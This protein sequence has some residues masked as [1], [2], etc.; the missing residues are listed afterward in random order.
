MRRNT[1]PAG[2]RVPSLAAF[3]SRN[4]IGSIP[5][6]RASSSTADSA[7]KAAAGDPGARYAADFCVFT[8]TSS[9]SI[10]A[11]GITYGASIV[12]QPD[13]TGEPGNA[14]ASYTSRA[15][16]AVSLPSFVAPIFT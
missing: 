14:P 11:L 9:P 4:S 16:A 1:G 5:S 6:L 10:C 13:G 12:R 3:S 15:H 2:C 7:A 8:T